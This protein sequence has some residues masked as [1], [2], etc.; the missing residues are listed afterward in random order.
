MVTVKRWLGLCCA[1]SLG[2]VSLAWG[3]ASGGGE[4][5]AGGDPPGVDATTPTDDGG[6][7]GDAGPRDAG[8]VALDVGDAAREF[9]R[10]G[11]GPPGRAEEL[12]PG[13]PVANPS[14]R[15][16]WFLLKINLPN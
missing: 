10:G 11:G 14:Q 16:Q 8:D 15:R 12:V 9:A 13:P 7:G 4:G 3:C 6:A 5:D 1:V 2:A